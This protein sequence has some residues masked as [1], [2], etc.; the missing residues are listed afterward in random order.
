ML[1]NAGG[2]D[3][4]AV[5]RVLITTD[6]LKV[7]PEDVEPVRRYLEREFTDN[8]YGGQTRGGCQQRGPQHSQLCFL[9]PCRVEGADISGCEPLRKDKE[10]VDAILGDCGYDYDATIVRVYTQNTKIPTRRYHKDSKAHQSLRLAIRFPYVGSGSTT[11][12][13]GNTPTSPKGLTPTYEAH[14][15]VN[16]GQVSICA[17]HECPVKVKAPFPPFAECCQCPYTCTQAYLMDMS[18]S[19]HAWCHRPRPGMN[20]YTVIFDYK[21]K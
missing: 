16:A 14:L 5:G 18:I 15:S 20:G 13:L 1:Q 3:D 2:A 4:R 6:E 11:F 12:D 9:F 7:A 10:Q 19:R 17:V 8:R 21:Y